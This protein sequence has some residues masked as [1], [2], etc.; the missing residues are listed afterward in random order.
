MIF[1]QQAELEAIAKNVPDG[2]TQDELEKLGKLTAKKIEWQ[3]KRDA[4]ITGI[5]DSI[6]TNKIELTRLIGKAYT[7]DD[8]KAAAVHFNLIASDKEQKQGTGNKKDKLI[9]GTFK[10]A[11]YGF[12]AEPQA[13]GTLP[14][15]FEWDFNNG[16]RGSSWKQKFVQA[17]IAKGVDDCMAKITPDFK[18]WLEISRPD[19][20]NPNKRVYEN[21]AAFYKAFGLKGDG[22]PSKSKKTA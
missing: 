9:V 8:L 1:P 7:T 2:L 3:Q 15:E 5:I 6:K 22:T 14:T 19:G 20:R 13:D 12:T 21:K 16:P 18:A 10:L 4:E 11:D 17:I